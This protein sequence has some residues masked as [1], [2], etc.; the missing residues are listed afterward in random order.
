VENSVSRSVLL[1]RYARRVAGGLAGLRFGPQLRSDWRNL[2]DLALQ[3][4]A[5]KAEC[6]ICGYRGV[7][8]DHAGRRRQVCPGC[9]SRARHRALHIALGD[10]VLRHALP[11]AARALHFA[12]EACLHHTVGALAGRVV[13]A[14]L[15]PRG[16]DLA[17]DICRLPFRDAS[18][19][20]VIASHVLEHVVDDRRALSEIRRVLAPG[21]LALLL[22]PVTA[23]KTVEYGAAD[24]LR[25]DHVREC[26]PDYFERY[27]EA[28]FE[29][30]LL[31]SDR[32]PGAEKHALLTFDRSSTLPHFLP[33]CRR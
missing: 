6:P 29:L 22:V 15:E 5:A 17:L 10:Y 9:G 16:V 11:R 30:E 18:F 7:F 21:G 33:F 1:R 25:N 19:G 4:A 32:L 24:P 14:D 31:R 20:L 12:P 8:L 23:Q 26:G 2:R 13:T 27:R 28:G 3:P